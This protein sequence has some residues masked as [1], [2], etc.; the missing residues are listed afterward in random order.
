MGSFLTARQISANEYKDFRT[1]LEK[2]SG[3]VLGENKQYLITSRLNRLMDAEGVDRFATLTQKITTNKA[4]RDKVLDAMTTNET[5]WFRDRYPFEMLKKDVFPEIAAQ[6]ASQ[7]KIWSAASSTGQEAYSISMTIQEYMMSRPGSLP[8]RIEIVGT[9][10][11]TS[12]VADARKGCYDG[13]SMAR[14][15]SPER[16]KQFFKQRPG[17]D[18]WELREDIRKR[19]VF[20]E[21]NLMSSYALLGKFDIIFCRNVLIYFSSELKREILEKI[22]G[23]LKPNGYLFLG[24][25]ESTAN[26]TDRFEMIKLPAGMLYKLRS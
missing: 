7:L 1:F 20:R 12:V 22:A 23:V 5:S 13:L 26:Y 6:R 16:K 4:L 25:S 10:I 17:E 3:I 8:S 24:G 14:G 9:D 11:S 19:V 2:A 18:V 21:L 15:L